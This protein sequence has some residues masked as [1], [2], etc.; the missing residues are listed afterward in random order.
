MSNHAKVIDA[1]S[2]LIEPADLWTSRLPTR[3]RDRAPR[4]VRHQETGVDEWFIGSVKVLGAQKMAHAGWK[5]FFPSSPSTWEEADPGA[6]DPKARLRVMDEHGISAQLVYPNL[7]GFHPKAFLALGEEV[8]TFCVQAYNDFLAEWCETDPRRLIPLAFLPFWDVDS[9]VSELNRCATLGFRGFNWGHKFD[10]VALPPMIDS[11]W[12]P[13]MALAQELAMP[14]S[15]HIGFG[16]SNTRNKTG[17]QEGQT[18][19]EYCIDLVRTTSLLFMGNASVIVDLC[20]GGLCE[21]YPDLAFVS[22][23]SGFGYIPFLLQ[24]MDWQYLNS[25]IAAVWKGQLLP[26]EYFRRQVY[27][28][29]WF[30]ADIERQIDLLPDNLMF[31][32]DYPHP[33]SL[34]PGPG[35]I[36][37]DARTVIVENLSGLSAEQLEK[38]LCDTA[39][40]IYKIDV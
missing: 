15:F 32:T 30:E 14:V 6:W 18:Y 25:E 5:E 10:Q 4:V 38:V 39:A 26:S 13:V 33:T 29:F 3:Y 17:L 1:D 21:R 28:T 20:V 9:C 19:D 23:E 37:G 31:S 2:H 22:V 16:G 40:R 36:A 24:A 35:S 12:D 8:A 7:I 34:S 27:A 11:H